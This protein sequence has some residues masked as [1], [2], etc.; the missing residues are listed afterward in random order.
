MITT[1]KQLNEVKL[2]QAQERYKSIPQHLVYTKPLKDKTANELTTAIKY[3]CEHHGFQVSRVN[4]MG[5]PK[6]NRRIVTDV[7]GFQKQI[8]S[9]EYRPSGSTKGASDLSIIFR[10]KSGTVVPWEVE[11]KIKDRQSMSQ[12]EYQRK[13]ETAGGTYSIV[14]SFEE[15]INIFIELYNM[16]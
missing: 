10:A 3:W 13:V 6:D 7:L 4:V 15:F 9:V 8:G 1:L 11:V 5:I 2:R 12:K 14:H 16:K